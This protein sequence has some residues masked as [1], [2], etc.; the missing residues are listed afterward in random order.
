SPP[1]MLA[2][3]VALV[4]FVSWKRARYFGNVAPLAIAALL[5]VLAMAA[6]S[7]P[8]EGF[9]LAALVFLFVFVAGVFA[10]LLETRH[11]MLVMAALCGLLIAS[12]LWNLMELA[13]AARP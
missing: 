4:A 6:P 7:F 11:G 3:P 2:L 1:L 13:R 10:D 9:Q 5:L 12:A 8:G